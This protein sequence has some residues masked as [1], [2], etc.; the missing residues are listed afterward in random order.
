MPRIETIF[1]D[2]F[3]DSLVVLGQNTAEI[4]T[5]E[6]LPEVAPIQSS[7]QVKIKPEDFILATKLVSNL[8]AQ[9]LQNRHQDRVSSTKSD[10]QHDIFPFNPIS[11]LLSMRQI[12]G[13]AEYVEKL[14]EDH[15]FGILTDTIK[16]YMTKLQ[17]IIAD[18]N[19]NTGGSNGFQIDIE[20][21]QYAM[22]KNFLAGNT[23]RT[24]HE[25]SLGK[26][27][28]TIYDRSINAADAAARAS[29][30]CIS[31]LSSLKDVGFREV[32]EIFAQIEYGNKLIGSLRRIEMS[33][34][35][36]K[37]NTGR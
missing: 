13:F 25:R 4:P 30:I 23:E 32:P 27:D 12:W 20:Q 22:I 24:K 7:P 26:N 5:G 3:L 19:E 17:G 35:S 2:I 14:S 8:S 1:D 6:Q 9:F 18:F 21:D 33:L 11:G 28:L 16:Q 31:L 34:R 15:R 37:Q 29:S 36:M 10:T